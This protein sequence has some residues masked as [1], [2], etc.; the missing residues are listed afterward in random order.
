MEII[1]SPR[2]KSFTGTISRTHGYAIRRVGNRF[3]SQRTYSR[4][5]TPDGH[6]RF[7]LT[8]AALAQAKLHIGDI[9]IEWEELR[10]ALFE[11]KYFIASEMVRRNYTDKN[12]VHYDARDIL[13]IKTTFGL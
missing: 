5:A 2:C 8:C 1:L 12:K 9:R 13:N 7:I 6:W 3:F 11:A 4:R 10:S